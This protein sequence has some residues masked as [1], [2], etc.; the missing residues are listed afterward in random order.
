MKQINNNTNTCYLLLFILFN[1]C[2][3]KDI[4]YLLLIIKMKYIC[5]R[6]EYETENKTNF[7]NHFKRK[8]KCPPVFCNIDTEKFLEI[9]KLK[10]EEYKDEL[11]KI[12]FE[13]LKLKNK[14]LMNI[15]N[16]NGNI[17]IGNNNT[18]TN[19]KIEIH[20]ND[21]KNTDY[22]LI[23]DGAKDCI[24]KDQTFDFGKFM[25]LLHFNE[26]FPQNHNVC[27]VN[28]KEK[29]INIYDEKSKKFIEYTKGQKGLEK[30]LRDK[31]DYIEKNEDLFDTNAVEASGI[32][33]DDYFK[34]EN[35]N[36]KQ[37]KDLL[38]E[39]VYL[40]ICNGSTLVLSEKR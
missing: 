36:E 19:I 28:K 23:R 20:I 1:L 38:Y 16:N 9:L 13:L 12:Q 4:K 24:K 18:N 26:D 17:N 37:K 27:I 5:L 7:I 14:Q 6:C 21:Y 30:I 34:Y 25:T 32:L 39:D 40:P 10:H 3:L 2:L 22:S 31:L 33:K 15:V 11:I 35:F 8:K 29:T